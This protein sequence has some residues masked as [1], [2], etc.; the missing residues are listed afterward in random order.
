MKIETIRV[1]NFKGLEDDVRIN[2]AG[3]SLVISG[4]NS[5]GK[6]SFIDAIWSILDSGNIPYKPINDNADKS[7]T[8]ISLIGADGTKIKASRVYTASGNTLKL[9]I[10]SEGFEVTKP[11]TYLKKLIGKNINFDPVHFANLSKTPK[12]RKEQSEMVQEILG[13]DLSEWDEKAAKVKDMR[14][15]SHRAKKDLAAKI[16][17]SAENMPT[18]QEKYENRMSISDLL[19][20]K[21]KYQEPLDL[22][23]KAKSK[24]D[25]IEYALSSKESNLEKKLKDLEELKKLIETSRA[26]ISA[27]K[28]AISKCDKY[29]TENEDVAQAVLDIESSM[30]N[31]EAHNDNYLKIQG[32]KELVEKLEK[33]D[34]NHKNL[35]ANFKD[36]GA[37]KMAAIEAKCNELDLGKSIYITEEGMLYVDKLPIEQLNTAQQ[38]EVGILL[39]MNTNP[40]L[41][42]LRL[43]VSTLDDDTIEIVKALIKK[44]DFQAFLEKVENEDDDLHLNIIEG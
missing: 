8:E 25:N 42:I 33:E 16:K 27:D 26:E 19:E 13:I 43:E 21:K 17:V 38:I 2:V 24:R 39:Y 9:E 44:H 34:L 37:Q 12:G 31:V 1:H 5:Q 10:G 4:K 14:L 20:E 36:I 3:N 40:K 7:A 35:D 29:I 41:R 23:S 28:A 32:H 18:D 15:V 22:I 11:A 30:K 6:S